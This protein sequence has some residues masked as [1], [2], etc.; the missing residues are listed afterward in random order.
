MKHLLIL[1]V[2]AILV[3]TVNAKTNCI[4]TLRSDKTFDMQFVTTNDLPYPKMALSGTNCHTITNWCD[5]IPASEQE[6]A[7][8]DLAKDEVICK[9]L[10]HSWRDGRPEEGHGFVL[11]D[12]HPGITFRTCKICGKCESKTEGDWR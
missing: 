10:E 6:Q 4:V 1:A 5:L 9:V 12:Y 3:V 2:L 7:V 8:N 11:A